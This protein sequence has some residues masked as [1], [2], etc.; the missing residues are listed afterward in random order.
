[1]NRKTQK[2]GSRMAVV[3]AALALLM[4]P[5]AALA[6]N[7]EL[8]IEAPALV[9]SGAIAKPTMVQLPGR[10]IAE[11]QALA[12]L[13]LDDGSIEDSIGLGGFIEMLW[14]NRFTPDSALFPFE[15]DEVSVLFSSA[16]LVSVGDDIT[17][18]LFENTAGSTD[19]AMG[20]HFLGSFDT[21]VQALNAW[22]VYSLPTPVT[23]NGPGDAVI[24]VISKE[25]PNNP[26]FWPAA[27]DMTASQGRS[28]AGS[29]STSPPPNPPTL[30]T[31]SWFLIDNYFPGNWMIRASGNS[32]NTPCELIV[33]HKRIRSDKLTKPHRIVLNVTSEDELF[34]VFGLI[35]LE[36]LSWQRVKFNQKNNRLEI[37]AIVPAGLAPGV[38]PISVGDCVGEVVVE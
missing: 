14:V 5:I 25:I 19:P 30:P 9:C 8:G 6:G 4:L 13:I 7:V 20:A 18:I 17:L 12:S 2:T 35:D 3:L 34:D 31:D 29:Y 26:S 10:D 22:N 32:I 27:I 36:P 11:P 38:Y 24:G 1:M 28:W 21:T 23:F 16:G 33:K 15:I 37:R